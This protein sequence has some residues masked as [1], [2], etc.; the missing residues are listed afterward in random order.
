MIVG[1]CYKPGMVTNDCNYWTQSPWSGSWFC[2]E[3]VYIL[4]NI[5]IYVIYC[6]YTYMWATKTCVFCCKKH[7]GGNQ[8]HKKLG[9]RKSLS[10]RMGISATFPKRFDG[11]LESRF[12]GNLEANKGVVFLKPKSNNGGVAWVCSTYWTYRF[13][14]CEKYLRMTGC[15]T[16]DRVE[17]QMKPIEAVC[18]KG[19]R[20]ER[21]FT[22]QKSTGMSMVLSK[23]M[24]MDY[25]PFISRL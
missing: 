13:F 19:G 22:I 24:Y 4:L 10:V 9:K 17:T 12:D 16:Y 15:G 7:R 21:F 3:F 1:G 14:R 25:N 6:I 5:H 23:W 11:N 20:W 2:E 18:K 8:K